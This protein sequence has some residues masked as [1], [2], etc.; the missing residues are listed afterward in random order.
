MSTLAPI[1]HDTNAIDFCFLI[2]MFFKN[3]DLVRVT[4]LY[5]ALAALAVG[6]FAEGGDFKE[7][8]PY[9]GCQVILCLV[10]IVIWRN[11]ARETKIMLSKS[12][13][14]SMLIFYLGIFPAIVS[15]RYL[16]GLEKT[17]LKVQIWRWL[18]EILV[19]VFRVMCAIFDRPNIQVTLIHTP[20]VRTPPNLDT[21]EVGFD[22]DFC[23]I[24]IEPIELGSRVKIFKC[25]H[26]IHNGCANEM[27]SFGMY[28]CPICRCDGNFDI[29]ESHK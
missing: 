17:V 13:L 11:R 27:F 4:F 23:P 22:G 15:K 26:P 18:F 10:E 19:C 5:V 20:V 1:A 6:H 21:L 14:S 7:L 28:A 2:R 9:S 16:V 8:T 12:C 3:L 25:G 29:D 24:C